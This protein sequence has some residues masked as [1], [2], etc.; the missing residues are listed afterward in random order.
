[1]EYPADQLLRATLKRDRRIRT[2]LKT[3][4]RPWENALLIL[5]VVGVFY[6]G[7]RIIHINFSLPYPLIA[8]VI[9]GLS[10]QIMKLQRRMDALM[11]VLNDDI[12]DRLASEL[13]K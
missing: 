6:I 10:A 2:A 3:R 7:S 4:I 11:E 12:E 13:K 8:I 9:F 1:M 5:L